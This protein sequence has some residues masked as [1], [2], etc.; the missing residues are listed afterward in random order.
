MQGNDQTA[1]I[2]AGA[3]P[4]GTIRVA[5]GAI[6]GFN[7]V[8]YVQVDDLRGSCKKVQELG[9]K[10]VPGFPFNLPDGRGA[11]AVIVDPVGHPLG[12]LSR[13]LLPPATK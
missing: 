13:T 4:I 10:V 11:I 7:G 1:E 8:V 5:D 6:S 3:S 9:G 12:L 2:V